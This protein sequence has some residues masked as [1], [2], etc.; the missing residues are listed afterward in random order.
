MLSR[1]TDTLHASVVISELPAMRRM[2]APTPLPT[3]AK[4]GLAAQIAAWLVARRQAPTARRSAQVV[5]LRA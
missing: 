4:P 5:F 1:H 3:L 2:P